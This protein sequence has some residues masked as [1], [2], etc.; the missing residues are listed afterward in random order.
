M[1]LTFFPLLL[2]FLLWSCVPE[3][4]PG[5][6]KTLEFEDKS[7][8]APELQTPPAVVQNPNHGGQM[9]FE[10][11]KIVLNNRCLNCHT[12]SVLGWGVDSNSSEQAWL[13][14]TPGGLIERGLASESNLVRRMIHSPGGNMP[15]GLNTTTF[16][17]AEY[18][19]VVSWINSLP[20]A[21]PLRSCGNLQHGQTQS[22]TRYQSATVPFGSSCVSETQLSAC[23][24]GVLSA[25]TGSFQFDSCTQAQPLSC[26][27]TAHGQ[28]ENR[29]R[30]QTSTVPF[31]SQCVS[32]IQTRT[33][34]NGVFGSFSG[35]FTHSSCSVEAA[36][37]CGNLSNGQTQTRQMFQAS[38][39][40]I[41]SSCVSEIQTRTCMNGTFSAY[42][43]TYTSATCVVSAPLNCGSV[44]HG[45][46]ESRT[47]YQSSTVAFGSTCA[48]EV[49]TRTC[50]NGVLSNFSGSY[51]FDACQVLPQQNTFTLA[52]SVLENRCLS[53][54]TGATTNWGVTAGATQEQWL[55]QTP[56][57][58]IVPSLAANSRVVTFMVHAGGNM[59]IGF[60][61]ETFPR[62]EYD[63][64]VTWINS[65]AP[66]VVEND[67]QPL[68][69]YV[70][71]PGEKIRLGD[72]NYIAKTM[73]AVFGKHS[74]IN[75]NIRRKLM[76]F[77]GPCATGMGWDGNRCAHLDEAFDIRVGGSSVTGANNYLHSKHYFSLDTAS[78]DAPLVPESSPVREGYRTFACERLV[79]G[80]TH[81]TAYNGPLY[82]AI[83]NIHQL[84]QRLRGVSVTTL[85]FDSYPVNGSR[86]SDDKIRAAYRLFYNFR[87][88]TAEMVE[89]YRTVAQTVIN[90]NL[91]VTNGFPTRFEPYRYL[92]YAM[93]VN[94]D[95]QIP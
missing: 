27:A 78:A 86:M 40:P 61:T 60:T 74:L 93:C 70:Y 51:S 72:R 48:S 45:Q 44:N 18:D 88:P 56:T 46:T 94:P 30:F 59:P 52:R 77:G 43:G 58:L 34:N 84:D 41:G 22:R 90:S 57:G 12:G 10:T 14:Q 85:N 71:Q 73:E 21:T 6:K 54:H 38:T 79:F 32:E 16:P 35:T 49:Q 42:S 89:R 75:D 13:E 55:T 92:L 28:T 5:E 1:K 33:C 83:Q 3:P 9:A 29:T 63:A 65:L 91:S 37:S 2:S 81:N 64:V 47:R 4:K 8:P 80:Q 23:H 95:W 67:N 87:E 20:Q 31:G 26:G 39:V 24:D 53:C 66:V 50:T 15:V 76:A 25:Y 36:A 68:S 11:A 7:T 62:S 19:A 69:G 17:R 82:T